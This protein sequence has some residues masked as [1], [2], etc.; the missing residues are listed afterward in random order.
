MV[1]IKHEVLKRIG[2]C[3]EGATRRQIQ[4]FIWDAQGHDKPFEYR[5]GYYGTNIRDWEYQQELITKEKR[6]AN[7]FLTKWGWKYV[8][9]PERA[10]VI[11]RAVRNKQKL[12][13]YDWMEKRMRQ[14]QYEINIL[15]RRLTRIQSIANESMAQFKFS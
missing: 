13:R 1:S 3:K 2:R 10:R 12:D 14:Q 4:E 6:G 7:Y 15:H 11:F 9:N 5:Q 8:A